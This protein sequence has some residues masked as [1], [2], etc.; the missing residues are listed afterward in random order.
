MAR[1]RTHQL[2]SLIEAPFEVLRFL[3]QRFPARTGAEAGSGS[4]LKKRAK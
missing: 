3:A 2:N 1:G 4:W